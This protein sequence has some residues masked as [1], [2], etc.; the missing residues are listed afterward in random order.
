MLIVRCSTERSE[1]YVVGG[2]VLEDWQQCSE[3]NWLSTAIVRGMAALLRF[4]KSCEEDA[5]ATWAIRSTTVARISHHDRTTT[6][7]CYGTTTH[8]H[9]NV[10]CSTT[11]P[12]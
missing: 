3:I 9:L 11:G 2:T 8:L 6:A 10:I 12:R 4:C 7:K 1:E 5:D